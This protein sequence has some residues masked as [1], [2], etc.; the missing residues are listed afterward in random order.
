MPAVS[1]LRMA[2]EGQLVIL[3]SQL[4]HNPVY[5]AVLDQ[6]QDAD[7]QLLCTSMLDAKLVFTTS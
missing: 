1:F 2:A 7:A 6:R 5:T 3:P 4:S